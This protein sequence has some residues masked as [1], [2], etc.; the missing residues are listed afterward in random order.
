MILSINQKGLEK[1][2]QESYPE[3]KLAHK[4]CIGLGLEIGGAEHNAFGL[5][6]LNVDLTDSMDTVFKLEEVRRCGK[7][8]KVDIVASG[9][10]VPRADESQDFI[11]SAHVLE[12]MPNPIKALLE[13]DRLI[14]PGGIIF[15]IVPHKERT[16]DR[17][18]ERT[19]L[20]HL[21]DDY[22]TDNTKA[23]KN[24]GGHHDHI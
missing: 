3:S 23:H 17:D 15:M 11:V 19:T 7:A 14:R 21:I 10:S 4:Y 12:H 20:Q 9:G 8:R 2:I 5:N 24:V 22:E 1:V 18:Y 6:T 13:W 16:F